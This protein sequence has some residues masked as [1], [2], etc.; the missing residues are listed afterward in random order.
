MNAQ[1]HASYNKNKIVSII[2]DNK[3]IY[4]QHTTAY[5]KGQ[6]LR[7]LLRITALTFGAKDG[8]WLG[9]TNGVG[10]PSPGCSKL[11]E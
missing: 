3:F 8:R 9:G 10:P 4:L 11:G 2:E 1:I 7:C 5:S 6:R